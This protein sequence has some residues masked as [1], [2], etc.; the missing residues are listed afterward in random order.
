MI[1]CL[2]LLQSIP[3]RGHNNT[4]IAIRFG[5]A[6]Q[7][8]SFGSQLAVTRGL[9]SFGFADSSLLLA[10]AASGHKGLTQLGS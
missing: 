2:V 3:L 10:A 5:I 9:N 6:P 7:F 8:C 4:C 1:V